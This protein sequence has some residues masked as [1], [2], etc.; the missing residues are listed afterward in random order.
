[1]SDKPRESLHKKQ[2]N[3]R[4]KIED[5]IAESLSGDALKSAMEFIAYLAQNKMKPAW[6][7]A[8]SW[9]VSYKGK[10][11]CYIR[12]PGTAWYQLEAGSWL[13]SVFSQY[14]EHL[15]DL[16]MCETEEIKV[17]VQKHIDNNVPC[18]GCMP[19]LDRRLVNSTFANVC[20]CTSINMVNPD[21][22]VYD[23]AVKLVA[24]RRD[25]IA[26]GRVPKCSYVK[27]ED[28]I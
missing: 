10:S 15:R 6:A 22:S 7:S 19:G 11:V 3:A 5:A 16:V 28:R 9:K 23:F 27:P 26:I 17:L 12:L 8:S 25:A 24:L 1:M 18:G 14:D 21:E 20:A 4:P 13:L 2:K